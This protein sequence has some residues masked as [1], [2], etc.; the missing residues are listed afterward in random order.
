[1]AAV[2]NDI[3]Y[4]DF[5]RSNND[6]ICNIQNE[7]YADYDKTNLRLYNVKKYPHLDQTD[8]L[9][10]MTENE[11]IRKYIRFDDSKLNN[12]EI[13]NIYEIIEQNR[14]AQMKTLLIKELEIPQQKLIS[15]LNYNGIPITADAIKSEVSSHL[16]LNNV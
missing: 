4:N 16:A 1:M 14:D 10:N 3:D 11:V 13:E 7:C 12:A 5:M 2:I 8:P 15:V 9:L 6:N